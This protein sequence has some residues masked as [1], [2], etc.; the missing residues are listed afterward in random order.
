M[1]TTTVEPQLTIHPYQERVLE[2]PQD[3]DVAMA[4]GRGGGK[5]RGLLYLAQRHCEEFGAAARPLYVRRSYPG[6]LDFEAQTREVFG[7]A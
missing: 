3:L 1:T 5:T 4:T 2:V 6:L 7:L